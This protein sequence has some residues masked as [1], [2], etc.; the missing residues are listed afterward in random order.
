MK[1]EKLVYNGT[2][3]IDTDSIPAHIQLELAKAAFPSIQEAYADPEIQKD[4]Q[5]WK[6]ERTKQHGKAD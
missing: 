2:I 3:R 4:F 1:K 5:R 6:A